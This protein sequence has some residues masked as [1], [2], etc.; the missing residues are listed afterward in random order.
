MYILVRIQELPY[1]ISG[2]ATDREPLPDLAF[3]QPTSPPSAYA[4]GW[5]AD[6]SIS[7]DTVMLSYNQGFGKL[8]ALTVHRKGRGQ[9]VLFSSVD[10]KRS[11]NL[12]YKLL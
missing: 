3:V 6:K 2:K 7:S 12:G 8:M 11:K 10:R 9:E 5:R 1:L 4:D